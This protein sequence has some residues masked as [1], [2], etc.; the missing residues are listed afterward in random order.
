MR[1]AFSFLGVIGLTAFITWLWVSKNQS[2]E[3]VRHLDAALAEA[4]GRVQQLET[5]MDIAKKRIA[6]LSHDQLASSAVFVHDSNSRVASKAENTQPPAIN[7]I[8]ENSGNTVLPAPLAPGI[9]P[10]PAV[11]SQYPALANSNRMRIEGTSSFGDW[12]V[13][14]RSIEGSIIAGEGFPLSS[15]TPLESSIANAMVNVI[16]P[17]R[18]LR[19]VDELGNPNSEAM[20]VL[21]KQGLRA[22]NHPWITFALDSL[23]HGRRGND[24]QSFLYESAGRLVIAGVTNSIKMPVQIKPERDGKVRFVCTTSFKLSDFNVR[25]ENPMLAG[26]AVSIGD[27]VKVIAQWYARPGTTLQAGK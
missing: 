5:D 21:L 15:K 23:S 18:W 1:R 20:D 7:L 19:S 16:V 27:E 22:E 8:S 24:G 6:Y 13:E 26:S 14:T 25:P 4:E 12:R 2:E 9:P 11:W 10:A 17:T 3:H